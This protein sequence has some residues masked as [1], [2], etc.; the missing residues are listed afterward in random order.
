MVRGAVWMLFFVFFVL[1]FERLS[2]EC[3]L[4]ARMFIDASLTSLTLINFLCC[5]LFIFHL[6][7]AVY[8]PFYVFSFSESAVCAPSVDTWHSARTFLVGSLTSLTV[9]GPRWQESNCLT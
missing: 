4:S 7:H 8:I 3:V 1:L 9:F 6:R 2:V 5:V